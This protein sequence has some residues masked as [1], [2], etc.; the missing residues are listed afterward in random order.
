MIGAREDRYFFAAREAE[1][2]WQAFDRAMARARG[3]PPRDNDEA[4]E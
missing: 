2:D 3:E 4:P 1:V